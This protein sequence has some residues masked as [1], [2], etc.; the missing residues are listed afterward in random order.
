VRL[1]GFRLAPHQVANRE[2]TEFI[3][4][5]GHRTEAE[6]LGWSYVFEGA[7]PPAKSVI[8][9]SS[10]ASWWLGVQGATWS[11]PEGPGSTV[12]DRPDHPVVHVSWNDA[13][14]YAE[15][16]GGRLPTEAEWE[17]AAR[18]G[19]TTTYPWGE[20]LAPDGRHMCNVWQGVFP[21]AD[22]GDD[23]W[24]GTAPVG[25][26]PANALGLYDMIG[27]V[28]EWCSD[29]FSA[30]RPPEGADPQGPSNGLGRVTKGGSFLCHRSYCARYRPAAR[31]SNTPD[32][33]TSHMGFRLAADL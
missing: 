13:R 14:A 2:F 19:S 20:E 24:R 4:Q 7:G 15:W 10:E 22:R 33:T 12:D 27:N 18:A 25:S 17:A 30:A 26:Y 31:T 8:G 32:S 23:G 21:V 9:R 29:W 3:R 6:R 1:A 11:S 16:A 28:W 5:T